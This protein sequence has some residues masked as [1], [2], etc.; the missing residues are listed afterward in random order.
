M[1]LG[2]KPQINFCHFFFFFFA[3]KF[4]QSVLT[5]GY[6]LTRSFLE[7]FFKGRG[8]KLSDFACF[9]LYSSV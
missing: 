9:N 7:D 4:C 8:H 1:W 6:L 2:H 5:I 3:G